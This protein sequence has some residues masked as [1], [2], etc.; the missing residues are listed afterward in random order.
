MRQEK[1]TVQTA[2]S[3]FFS[4]LLAFA[5]MANSESAPNPNFGHGGMI[6]WG[7]LSLIFA[8]AACYFFWQNNLN[9]QSSRTLRYQ[10]GLLLD[11]NRRLRSEV[12]KLQNELSQA[13]DLLRNRDQA[14]KEKEQFLATAQAE[15]D[16]YLAE[17]QAQ[18]K[19]ARAKQDLKKKREEVLKNLA[20]GKDITFTVRA[21]N[22]ILVISNRLLFEVGYTSLKPDS[23]DIL[24]K[25]AAA[26]SPLLTDQELHIDS[27]TDNDPVTGALAQKFP[28]NLELSTARANAVFRYLSQT[29]HLPADHLVASGLGETR[30]VASNDSPEGKAKNRRVEISLEPWAGK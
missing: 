21:G 11:E 3:H 19:E 23:K 16:K 13:S 12:D 20:D 10:D 15:K 27:H 8:S 18:E 25:I 24:D 2:T 26:V 14:L 5:L 17:K 29:A 1:I 22:P 6:F 7:G 9:E 30:P 28:S 4:P